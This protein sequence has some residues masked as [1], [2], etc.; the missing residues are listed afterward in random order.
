MV[1]YQRRIRVIRL[2][3][4]A[5]GIAFDPTRWIAAGIPSSSFQGKC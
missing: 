1:R 4:A 5:G 2:L 3:E